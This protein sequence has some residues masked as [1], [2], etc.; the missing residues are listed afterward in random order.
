MTTECIDTDHE[1]CPLH[2]CVQYVCCVPIVRDTRWYCDMT[3]RP[4]FWKRDSRLGVGK[5]CNTVVAHDGARCPNTSRH[6]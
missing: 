6:A 2:G 5:I 3:L 1:H 4:G